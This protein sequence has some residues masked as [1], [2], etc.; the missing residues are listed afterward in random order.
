MKMFYDDSL[1]SLQLRKMPYSISIQ[2]MLI[3][4]EILLDNITVLLRGELVKE[5]ARFLFFFHTV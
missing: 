2:N 5:Q 1:I 3:N 4:E